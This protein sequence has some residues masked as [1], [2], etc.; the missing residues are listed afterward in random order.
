MTTG[1]FD[2][3]EKERRLR[4]EADSWDTASPVDAEPGD[5]PTIDI[6][7]YLATGDST[8]LE[9]V[10]AQLGQ[11]CE[12]VGFYQLVGHDIPPGLITDTFAAVRR[13]HDL[14][15]E[16]KLKLRMDRPGWP[17]GGVGYLPVGERKLPRRA[18]G[19][20]NE[21]FIVKGDRAIGPD[22]NQWPDEAVIPGFR[23]TI[24]AYAAAI[25]GLALRLL[26]IYA[27]ALGVEA[28]YFDGAFLYPFWRLRMTHYPP[29]E[30]LGADQDQYGISPHVDTTFLT[31][32][33]QDSPGLTIYNAKRDRWINVPVIE[34]AFVVNSGELLKQWA[35]DRYVSARHFANTTGDASRYSIPF[36]FNATADYRM[37]CIPTCWDDD[38]P[39]RYPP[40]SYLESQAIAQGE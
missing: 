25:K 32:L 8:T 6:G 5:I 4:A 19:N 11:A 10:A 21:A 27:M 15:V 26:P 23:S 29:Q 14:P 2:A 30:Q 40:I 33:L 1:S 24:E 22:D 17:L 37:H 3:E 28:H 16:E 18:K 39:P 9:A 7:D 12:T 13:F 35:N 38:N 20:L 31:L 34:N 36:F